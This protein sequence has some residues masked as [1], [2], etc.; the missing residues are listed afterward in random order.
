MHE[1]GL[2]KGLMRQIDLIVDA[3][4]GGR[5]VAVSVWL[6]ALSHFSPAHFEEH[7]RQASQGARAEGAQLRVTTSDDP[8][9]E[10]ALD[11]VLESV[12]VEV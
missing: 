11:V 10:R 3:E 7:F 2:V 9:H 8:E 5:V 6:G 12:E 4:G 1:A